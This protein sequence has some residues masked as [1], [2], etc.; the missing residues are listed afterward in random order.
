MRLLAEYRQGASTFAADLRRSSLSEES[1]ESQRAIDYR[2]ALAARRVDCRALP[3]GSRD[4]REYR[5]DAP[6]LKH[7]GECKMFQSDAHRLI[8]QR[9]PA[10]V[11]GFSAEI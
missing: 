7:G 1:I 5:A 11:N 4:C 3:T 6:T 10:R 8:S 9:T 2:R